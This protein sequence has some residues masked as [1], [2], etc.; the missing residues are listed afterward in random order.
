MINMD[1][2]GAQSQGAFQVVPDAVAAGASRYVIARASPG[3]DVSM[4]FATSGHDV[5]SPVSDSL[6]AALVWCARR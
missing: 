6:T 3:F 5:N 1:K 2:Y 4:G